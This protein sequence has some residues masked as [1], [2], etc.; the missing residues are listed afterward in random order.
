MQP[1]SEFSQTPHS[2]YHWDG[3]SRRFFEGWY[4]RVTLPDIGESFAFMHS[5]EDPS[6]GSPFSGG[7][8]QVLGIDE[9]YCYR[10]FPNPKSFWAWNHAL[11]LGHWGKLD[12]SI[13]RHWARNTRHPAYLS[14]HHFSTYI[15]E[16]YQATLNLHQGVLHDPSGTSVRWHYETQPVYGWGKAGRPQQS[17]AGWLS[18]LQIF[19][20]GW[21]VLMAH[22]LASGWIEWKGKRYELSQAPA[23]SEKNWGGAF[24][25]KWFWIQCNCFEGQ[26]DLSLTA[27]GGKRLVLGW[28][29]S[30]GM[31]GIH[32]QGEFYEFVPW[33]SKI[34]WSVTPW[35]DW[36]VWAENKQYVAEVTGITDRPGTY[37]RVP[38]AQGLAFTCRDTTQGRV[39]VRLWTSDQRSLILSAQSHLGGLEVG[40]AP[41]NQAWNSKDEPPSP[42]Q[43]LSLL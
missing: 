35:G 36:Q 22:G 5:I 26:A 1:L 32:Y 6:G 21:Q 34:G 23:Y 20:P 18:S 40:G 29:E 7:A 15:K 42:S 4:F 8:T 11:G 31:I 38:T 24:P 41:W 16:G 19:E 17:T 14:P 39:A 10:T 27:V 43:L 2:G 28:L 25:Q 37:V 3:S 9:A 33:N 30:V 13:P 12:T